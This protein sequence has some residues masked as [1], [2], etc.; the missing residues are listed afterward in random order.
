MYKHGSYAN[1]TNNTP[2]AT[3]ESTSGLQV[4]FGTAPINLASSLDK[5][6]E[7]IIAYNIEEAKTA[8]GYSDDWEKFTLCESMYASF[9][10]YKVAPVIFVNVLDPKK[11]ITDKSETV[12]LADKKVILKEAGILLDSVVIRSEAG[13]E[14]FAKNDDYMATLETDGTILIRIMPTDNI[15]TSQTELFVT[16]SILD[17]TK[18]TDTDVIGGTDVDTGEMTGLAL[19]DA[20]FPM[21]GMLPATIIAPGFSHKPLI[22]SMIRAKLENINT[23]FKAYF[24]PDADTTAA[25]HYSKVLDWKNT[26]GYTSTSEFVCWP[27][28]GLNDKVFHLSSHLGA[29]I[30]QTDANNNNIP[31]QSPSNRKLKINKV[32]IEKG[33]EIVFGPDTSNMLNGQGIMTVIN[34]EGWK[35]WGNRPGNFASE[36][37][38][39]EPSDKFI[40]MKRQRIWVSNQIILKTWD[41]VD[42]S[43]SRR[44]AQG[45]CDELNIWFN[46]LVASNNMVGGRVE[47]RNE[48][49]PSDNLTNGHVKYKVFLAES[50]PAEYQEF[51]L[52]FDVTYYDNMFSEEE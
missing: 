47:F 17:V 37:V 29:L 41:S 34:M 39:T 28:V 7:P 33:K 46:G 8:L 30:A 6:N 5:V 43:I 36:E 15:P 38:S 25:N 16:Y 12:T 23:F 40:N 9:E 11:H 20:I 26:N 13:V 32:L 21:F 48:D 35:S 14:P 49:N 1:T 18:V 51:N 45:I 27:K 19:I 24:I 3:V 42:G 10:L 44:Q 52:E 22:A 2:A 31:S 50:A 4:V